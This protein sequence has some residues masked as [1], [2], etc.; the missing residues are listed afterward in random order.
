MSHAK[1]SRPDLGEALGLRKGTAGLHDQSLDHRRERGPSSLRT[2]ARTDAMR[3]VISAAGTPI[4]GR[5]KA[6]TGPP[7][8]LSKRSKSTPTSNVPAK[9]Q[10]APNVPDREVTLPPESA[11]ALASGAIRYRARRQ[12]SSTRASQRGRS[13]D[14]PGTFGFHWH[15]LWRVRIPPPWQTTRS[16]SSGNRTSATVRDSARYCGP[17]TDQN[18][19]DSNPI[20]GYLFSKHTLIATP[21]I[22][23]FR[24]ALTAS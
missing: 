24:L 19:R 8:T 14:A 5:H 22:S 10:S 15:T 23:P 6:D 4:P 3:A 13:G 9:R 12:I 2:G 18:G 17:I 1:P 11:L 21:Q 20:P 16:H 7:S